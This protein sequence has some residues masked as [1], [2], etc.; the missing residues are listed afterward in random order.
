M[1]SR[2]S[3][4]EHV[5]ADKILR[6]ILYAT[7][8]SGFACGEKA[9]KWLFKDR[10]FTVISNGK[11]IDKFLFNAEIRDEYRNKLAADKKEILLGHVGLFHKQKNHFFLINTFAK[12]CEKSDCYRLVLIGEG[13]EMENVRKQVQNL[14]LQ[15]KV[16]FLGRQSDVQ[17]WLQALDIMVFPSLFEGMPNVVLEWQIAGLPSIISDTITKECTITDNVKYLSLHSGYDAWAD[18]ILKTK[19]LS[20]ENQQSEIRETF[21]N[22]GF[23]IKENATALKAIYKK[24]LE[25]QKQ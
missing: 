1:H 9:G 23:D 18:A 7:Y 15:N 19:V 5:R 24:L 11:D 6:P 14:N 25:N 13:E 10:P 3:S 20:R 21:K 8:T 17:N 2:N 4:C 16:D 12:V 22:A